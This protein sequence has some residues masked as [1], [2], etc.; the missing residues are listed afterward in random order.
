MFCRCFLFAPHKNKHTLRTGGAC[1][2]PWSLTVRTVQTIGLSLSFSNS[3]LLALPARGLLLSIATKVTKNA[4]FI[5][6]PRERNRDSLRESDYRSQT[7]LQQQFC[8]SPLTEHKIRLHK[9]SLCC[10]LQSAKQKRKASANFQTR[11]FSA[12]RKVFSILGFYFI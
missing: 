7:R 10:A 11:I 9:R 5:R 4:L 6:R 12:R 8:S 3:A 2:R 1:N